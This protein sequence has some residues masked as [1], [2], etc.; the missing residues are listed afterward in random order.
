MRRP[1]ILL[2]AGAQ[3]N[4]FDLA[5]LESAFDEAYDV[6]QGRKV[7]TQYVGAV[8]EPWYLRHPTPE[9]ARRGLRPRVQ[10]HLPESSSPGDPDGGDGDARAGDG[11][12]G[13]ALPPVHPVNLNPA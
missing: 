9:R 7:E 11:E 5:A 4:A 12:A 6:V 13:R 2:S 3:A 10:Q 1:F 8:R